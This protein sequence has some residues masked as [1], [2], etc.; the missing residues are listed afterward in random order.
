MIDI[1]NPHRL[2]SANGIVLTQGTVVVESGERGVVRECTDSSVLVAW[3]YDGM[4]PGRGQLGWADPAMLRAAAPGRHIGDGGEVRCGDLM[5]DSTCHD[6]CSVSRRLCGDCCQQEAADS[7]GCG[8]LLESYEMAPGWEDRAVER[9]QREGVVKG[10]P[11]MSALR[12]HRRQ[13]ALMPA[14]DGE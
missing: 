5:H 1:T 8:M 11:T 3:H 12:E 9:A 13:Q 2:T 10:A 4:S 14:D 6:T 7:D